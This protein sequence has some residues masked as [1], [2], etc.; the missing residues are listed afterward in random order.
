MLDGSVPFA[1]G[2]ETGQRN[3]V[4]QQAARPALA[5]VLFQNGKLSSSVGSMELPN[6]TIALSGWQRCNRNRG[7]IAQTDPNLLAGSGL[8]LG[9]TSFN[10]A[11]ERTERHD[12]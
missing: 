1:T 11:F 6:E 9:A 5:S 3:C 2:M 12:G 4:W 8:R 7:F 10:F